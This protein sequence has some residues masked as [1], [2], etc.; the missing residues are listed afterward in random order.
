[1]GNLARTRRAKVKAALRERGWYENELG[2]LKKKMTKAEA[3]KHLLFQRY[4][5]YDIVDRMSKQAIQDIQEYEDRRIFAML[6]NAAAPT[7]DGG[8]SFFNQ[9]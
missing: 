5:E 7:V 6:E 4:F 1:M 3:R 8:V 9:P 2:E